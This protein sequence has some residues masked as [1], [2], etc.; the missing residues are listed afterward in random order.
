MEGLA[1]GRPDEADARRGRER[2][3]L[4][5]LVS[6]EHRADEMVRYGAQV[7]ESVLNDF[8]AAQERLKRAMASPPTSRS[9]MLADVL[10]DH[11][12][13]AELRTDPERARGL[14]IEAFRLLTTGNTELPPPPTEAP[15]TIG[16]Q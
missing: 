5:A 16:Q 1:D 9:S 15:P 12:A 2:R 7:P 3:L 6:I 14:A 11:L 13:D 4:E 8:I 10:F